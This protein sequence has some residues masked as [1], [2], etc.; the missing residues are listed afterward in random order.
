M[1]RRYWISSVILIEYA[2]GQTE[3]MTHYANA[4]A[5]LSR[6][7]GRDIVAAP[8]GAEYAMVELLRLGGVTVRC[9]SL[10]EF[11]KIRDQQF[12]K[13]SQK[14]DSHE[15]TAKDLLETLG[16]LL[17][18]YCELDLPEALGQAVLTALGHFRTVEVA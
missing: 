4:L 5:E 2:V 18:R 7:T 6:S 1:P 12:K 8:C 16:K 10:D 13:R 17:S 11:K 3:S 9:V 15:K 14:L